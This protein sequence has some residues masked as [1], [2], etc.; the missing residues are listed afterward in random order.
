[1]CFIIYSQHS[2]QDIFRQALKDHR[3]QLTVIR[4]S[5]L[6]V[7][8]QSI[9]SIVATEPIYTS[10]VKKQSSVQTASQ[11]S[12]SSI[13]SP[14]SSGKCSNQIFVCFSVFNFSM[15]Y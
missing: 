12:P 4:R 10:V 9:L 2:A 6:P 5:Y 11:P 7:V 1:M 8:S 15:H 3:L 13:S 14:M